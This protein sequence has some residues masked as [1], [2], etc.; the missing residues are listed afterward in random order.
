MIIND[1]VE[2]S[3]PDKWKD[4]SRNNLALGGIKAGKTNK[5]LQKKT[6]SDKY[7]PSERICKICRSKIQSNMFYCNDCAH[8][9]GIC[10]MC[11]KK[12]IDTSK[13]RMSLK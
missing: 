3:V 5:V 8:Q 12:V 9:K 11:G 7:I 2:Y 4:G 1:I 6:I 13:H 10:T